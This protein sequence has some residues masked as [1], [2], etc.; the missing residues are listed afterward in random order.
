MQEFLR[1]LTMVIVPGLS[2]NAA[3]SGTL[4]GSEAA[5]AEA[6]LGSSKPKAEDFLHTMKK[7]SDT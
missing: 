2:L 4:S 5:L 7:L 6:S 3:T 1:V